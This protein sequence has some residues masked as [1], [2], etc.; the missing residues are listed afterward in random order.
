M[1]ARTG[2]CALLRK[3]RSERTA[4]PLA[5][6]LSTSRSRVAR[7]VLE[8]EAYWSA[9]TVSA[10]RALARE[11]AG[12][13][14]GRLT[15]RAR[16]ARPQLANGRQTLAGHD[17]DGSLALPLYS[18][19]PSPP[20]RSVE[21]SLEA[22]RRQ[23]SPP[24][25]LSLLPE[26]CHL[27]RSGRLQSSA[28]LQQTARH[29]SHRPPLCGSASAAQ[30]AAGVLSR[31]SVA[32]TILLKRAGR[33]R[34][35]PLL[36]AF[37]SSFSSTPVRRGGIVLTRSGNPPPLIHIVNV[38]RCTARW[39]C[40]ESSKQCL[41]THCNAENQMLSSARWMKPV[42]VP[43]CAETLVLSA[44]PPRSLRAGKRVAVLLQRSCCHPARRR[45]TLASSN[46]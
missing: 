32:A 31:D 7:A 17:T 36:T 8:V 28:L 14:V 9:R 6:L 20:H 45:R 40:R 11:G 3:V 19:P 35:P 18:Q 41:Y 43:A 44:C 39:L 10:A 5:R 21:C 46:D 15:A 24:S 34:M 30:A 29:P 26:S 12:G 4:Q 23:C 33:A 25:W 2:G 1:P 13:G 27:R 16:R 37:S 42:P 38:Y 22:R